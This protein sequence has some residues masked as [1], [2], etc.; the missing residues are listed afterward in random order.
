M[1]SQPGK[2]CRRFCATRTSWRIPR[3]ASDKFP[4]G[5][6][7]ASGF[8]PSNQDQRIGLRREGAPPRSRQDDDEG[9]NGLNSPPVNWNSEPGK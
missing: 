5:A 8:R 6:P 2:W 4:T 7:F 1:M 9:M 3:L